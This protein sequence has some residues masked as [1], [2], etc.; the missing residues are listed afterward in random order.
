MLLRGCFCCVLVLCCCL[1]L[2]LFYFLG[3]GGRRTPVVVALMRSQQDTHSAI[4]GPGLESSKNMNTQVT[5]T[6]QPLVWLQKKLV[7]RPLLKLNRTKIQNK[8]TNKQTNKQLDPRRRRRKALEKWART[9]THP[10]LSWL[11]FGVLG[12]CRLS[13]KV[14]LC[15]RHRATSKWVALNGK[16]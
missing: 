8:Q 6:A 3:G 13:L 12:C 9:R 4:L 14:W 16:D 2:L 7:C 1:F 11:F 10:R 15:V 5:K